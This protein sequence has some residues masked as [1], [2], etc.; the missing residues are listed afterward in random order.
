MLGV[1]GKAPATQLSQ[2]LEAGRERT[3]ELYLTTM[4]EIARN[5]FCSEMS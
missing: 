2:M 3:Q 4:A 5:A 1:A